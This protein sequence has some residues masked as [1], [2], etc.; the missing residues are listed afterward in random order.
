MA[1]PL[2]VGPATTDE[3][4]TFYGAGGEHIVA[5]VGGQAVAFASIRRDPMDGRVWAGFDV[6]PAGH[7]HGV[8]IVRAMVRALRVRAE[9]I[10]VVCGAQYPQAQRLLGVLGFVPVGETVANGKQVWAWLR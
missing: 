10:H 1:A 5:R 6:A 9:T 7:V 3:I 2:D 4:G 8:A